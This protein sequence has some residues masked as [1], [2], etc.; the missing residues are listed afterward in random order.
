MSATFKVW[1]VAFEITERELEGVYVLVLRG[2]LVLGEESSS[3]RTT[4]ET[5]LS[6]GAARIVVSLYDVNSIG[7]SGLGSLIG[8]LQGSKARGGLLKLASPSPRFMQVLQS[9]DLQGMFEIFP[10]EAAAIQSF[11]SNCPMH[12]PYQGPPLCPKGSKRPAGRT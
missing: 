8:A 2:R 5:L 6:K 7:T 1:T 11:W 4:V 3:F 12:G 10:T 9:S